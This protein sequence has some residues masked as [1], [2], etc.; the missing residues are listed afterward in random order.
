MVLPLTLFMG[1]DQLQFL[2][3][4][5]L[6]V[7]IL[8]LLSLILVKI[9]LITFLYSTGFAGGYI[10]PSFFIG[11][12]VGILVYHFFPFIPLAICVVCGIAG[13]SVTLLRS[14]IALALIIGLIF[15]VELVPAVAIALVTGFLASY[16]Y[17]LPYTR[18]EKKE[19]TGFPE[20]SVS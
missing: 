1:T 13:V 6:E 8:L 14:P 19:E 16:R 17:S 12:T 7:G 15:Q 11:G 10:F 20:R 2:V 18:T 5:Y 4:N 9:L 3:D